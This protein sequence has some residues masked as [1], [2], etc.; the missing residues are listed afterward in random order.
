MKHFLAQVTVDLRGELGKSGSNVNPNANIGTIVQNLAQIILT[1]GGIV[2]FVW[3]LIGGFNWIS[4][5]GDKAKIDA[6]KSQITQGL[7]GLFIL[8]CSF[9]IFGVIQKLLGLQIVN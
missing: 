1:L 3:F 8:A 5:G 7:V 9:A 6:A 2:A 4:S